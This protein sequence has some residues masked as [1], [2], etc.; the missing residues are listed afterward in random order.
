MKPLFILV[1][2]FSLFNK[3]QAQTDTVKSIYD[4][5]INGLDGKQQQP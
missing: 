3:N 2:M 1:I 4:I 5:A